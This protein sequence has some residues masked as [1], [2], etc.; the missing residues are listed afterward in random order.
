[1]TP[2]PGDEE[3]IGL[4]PGTPPEA[5]YWK[6]RGHLQVLFERH[7]QTILSSTEQRII[8]RIDRS[9][10]AAQRAET[11][12]REERLALARQLRELEDQV[13][14][15]LEEKLQRLQEEATQL[16]GG[17]LLLKVIFPIGLASIA[18]L[19]GLLN[20]LKP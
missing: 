6:L 9:D 2:P 5:I 12:H 13:P 17:L 11:Q 14:D 10:L 18:A 8:E 3:A 19:I 4:P 20:Y 15:R 16:R 7:L 1:M